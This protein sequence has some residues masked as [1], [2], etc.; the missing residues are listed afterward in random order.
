M[1]A[2]YFVCFVFSTSLASGQF[3]IDKVYEMQPGST[4]LLIRSENYPSKYP[5]GK[6]Y[7]YQITVPSFYRVNAICNVNIE[8][9]SRYLVVSNTIEAHKF[10]SV[11]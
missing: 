9:S 10:N 5:I 2:L 3:D 11:E 1:F 7:R 4:P 8:V 6:K